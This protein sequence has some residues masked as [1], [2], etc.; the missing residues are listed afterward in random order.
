MKRIIFYLLVFIASCFLSNESFG[1]NI[2][3]DSIKSDLEI[4]GEVL[5]KLDSKD[6]VEIIKFKEQLLNDYEISTKFAVD[7]TK[8][9]GKS[10]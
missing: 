3:S 7:P 4:S 9:I 6:I 10:P 8:L 2:L 1:Q 5:E